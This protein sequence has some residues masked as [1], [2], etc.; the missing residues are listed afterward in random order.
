M[1]KEKIDNDLKAALKN[2]ESVKVSTLR[3]LKA[4]LLNEKIAKKEEL[5]DEDIIAIIKKQV[6]QRKDSIEGFKKGDRQDLADKEAEELKI[7]QGY[8]PEELDP[9]ELLGIVTEA[10]VETKAA[11]LKDMGRVIKE[12]MARV[13]GRADGKTVSD[14]VKKELTK[15]EKQDEG[16]ASGDDKDK[17]ALEK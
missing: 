5:E 9:Q 2:K 13:K 4:A 17:D 12:V 6:K 16:E 8:L 1:L 10:V 11:S 14:L 3:L 7:L 15:S